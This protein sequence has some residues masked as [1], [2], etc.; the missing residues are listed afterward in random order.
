MSRTAASRARIAAS[1]SGSGLRRRINI[2]VS[3]HSNQPFDSHAGGPAGELQPSDQGPEGPQ[4][5]RDHDRSSGPNEDRGDEGCVT[6]HGRTHGGQRGRESNRQDRDVSTGQDVR[7]SF[8]DLQVD[9]NLFHPQGA[10]V[11]AS[12]R[13]AWLMNLNRGEDR[14]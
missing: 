11:Q 4:L 9:A 2:R 8:R 3:L 12:R 13:L 6:Q 14:K 10:L 7:R 1:N 5:G